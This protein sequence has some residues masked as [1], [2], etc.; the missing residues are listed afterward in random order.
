M[1]C[2]AQSLSSASDPSSHSGERRMP[3]YRARFRFSLRFFL[4]LN[5]L[6]LTLIG[7]MHASVAYAA[8]AAAE[9]L[10]Q[11]SPADQQQLLQRFQSAPADVQQQAVQELQSLSPTQQQQLMQRYQ[12]ASPAERQQMMQ[13]AQGRAD[14]NQTTAP[15]PDAANLAP[16]TRTA[17]ASEAPTLDGLP[18][19]GYEVFSGVPTT[20]APVTDIPIPVDYLLGPGDVVSVQLFG[21]EPATFSLV[22]NRDGAINFPLLGPITVAGMMFDDVRALLQERVGEQMIGTTASVTLGELRSIRIFVL[23]EANRP[24]A[25]TVSSLSTII[26]A[27]LAS[28]GVKYSGSLRNLQLKR[29]GNVV[30]TLDLYDVLLRGDTTADV[31]LKPG[32]VIFIPPVGT[33]VG[34]SGEVLRPAVYELTEEKALGDALELAGGL[35]NTAYPQAARLSRVSTYRE[36]MQQDIDL[37]LPGS[38][39]LAI[40]NGDILNVPSILD[41]VDNVVTLEGHVLR[42]GRVQYQAG[43]RLT[44][45]IASVEEL[46]P[47]PD[48]HYVLIRREEGQ[49]R[50]V[51]AL[52]ADLQ[53]AL[54]NR[55]G[56]D[57][58]PLLPRDQV[59]V[60]GI[61]GGRPELDA[62][63][64]ELRLQATLDQAAPVVRIAGRVRAPGDYPLEP[65]MQVSDLLRAGG[66]LSEAAYASDAEITRY[67]VLNGDYRQVGLVNVNL[68][69][70][71]Q[72]DKLADIPLRPYDFLNVREVT[73]WREQET[74]T[75]S[76]EIRF[77]GTYPIRRGETL[78][79]VLERA[80]GLTEHAYTNGAVFTRQRLIAQEQEQLDQ[81]AERLEA[82]LA[83][84]QLQRANLDEDQ[85]NTASAAGMAMLQ[86]LRNTRPVGR[87]AMDF[88]RMI[89]ADP[90]SEEDLVLENGD[91]L[92]VPGVMQSVS[93]LGEVQ[94]PTS[95][96]SLIHI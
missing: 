32:D 21:K 67:E 6:V 7:G 4:A 94:T 23:G 64:E 16:E 93:V 61:S 90:G 77:P 26:N 78:L 51:V 13:Q 39:S 3:E 63:V 36:R 9:A 10:S 31:R 73:D 89:T 40:R 57:N 18:F 81:L 80:G 87:L 84:L 68:A 1:P 5:C 74:V 29:D 92:L 17:N 33:Q 65:D 70:I 44:D 82:D 54:L 95:L 52:S 66:A 55:N 53:R 25:Y 20:F 12:S 59:R 86:Q 72:G 11:L 8:D 41:R 35:L 62:L 38:Q 69:A 43:M 30:T 50:R 76:G 46:Q 24:G 48:L 22:V 79:S 47:M 58:V 27:L 49:E 56:P 2:G 85:S 91:V 34:L 37:R 28:G 96:L 45:L 60:F 15:S 88:D 83:S 71:R 75:L 14:N 19:F 42:P